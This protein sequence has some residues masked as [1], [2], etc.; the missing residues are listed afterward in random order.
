MMGSELTVLEVIYGW[1]TVVVDN[2]MY[3]PITD[4]LQPVFSDPVRSDYRVRG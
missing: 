3:C 4:A 1:D 2:R